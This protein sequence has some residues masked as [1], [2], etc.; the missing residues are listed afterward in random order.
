MP[1]GE[2]KPVHQSDHRAE[3]NLMINLKNC[4]N[5]ST[6]LE[7]HAHWDPIADS[8]HN[9]HKKSPENAEIFDL[10]PN[11]TTKTYRGTDF[12]GFLP[13]S[14]VAV[15]DIWKLDLDKII[16]F[17]VQFHTGATGTLRHGQEGAFA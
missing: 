16:P 15:G 10:S 6:S 11:E 17:L 7:V 8:T 2:A 13:S 3:K 12:N 1:I 4:L 14:A 5:D 9:L